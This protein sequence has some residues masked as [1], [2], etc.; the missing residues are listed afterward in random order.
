[1]NN[2]S[3]DED[4]FHHFDALR[5][6]ALLGGILLH[7]FMSYMPGFGETNWPLSDRSTNAGLGILFF[8]IHL[9]RMSLFYLI[10]GFFA[11]LLHQRLGTQGLIKNRLKRIGLPLIAF[12][13]LAVPPAFIAL[14]WG[15][16]QLGIK[17]MA[18][19][20][21]LPPV[22]GLPIPWLHLWFLYLLLV[23][24]LL[25]LTMRALVVRLDSEGA[26]RS[27]LSRLLDSA[28]SLRIA[29]VLLG[30]PIAV[31]LFLSPWWVQWGGIP[32]P[33]IGLVP[34]FPGL[35]AYG[36]AFLVGWFLHREQQNLRKL[37][38][39]WLL[40]A[41]GAALGTALALHFVGITPKFE[42]IELSS[43]ERA[44]YAGAYM[45]AQWCG[46]LA[47]VGFTM[48]YLHVASPR[49]R[50]LAD[51]SYWM[52]L[53]HFPIVM[54]LQA[55]MLSWPMHWSIKLSLILITV[56]VLLLASYHFLVRSTYIGVF[57]SGRKY[58][59]LSSD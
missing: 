23:I 18:S 15:A 14:I 47:V 37:A 49:W 17:G 29:P 38:S 30:A 46:I 59:R 12:Y 9:V 48:Q 28:F 51:A 4:R 27:T 33:I 41:V 42:I 5:A 2:S 6:G 32:S 44:V 10:A 22:V 36:T 53:I 26:L 56:S 43:M 25:A 40:Y 11:R 34:N 19:K 21:V 55:W 7:A 58:P 13:F 8:V 52:Y 50:Y 31:A 35:L 20:A 24:C 3:K 57:L 39:D 45:F 16:R 54:L 1:M